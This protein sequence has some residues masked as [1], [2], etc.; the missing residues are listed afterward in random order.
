MS[1]STT[2][3]EAA[4]VVAH[5]VERRIELPGEF[6]PYQQTAIHAKVA[7]FVESV[8][9]DRGSRVQEG[10]LLASMTA[11]E[12]DAQLAE[13]RAR[14]QIMESDVAAA[15]A[16]VAAPQSTYEKLRG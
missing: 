2:M 8:P 13:A 14:V 10:Q 3:R 11:P 12:M 7:G 6:L 4:R 1:D 15:Q 9:V 5:P 16:R